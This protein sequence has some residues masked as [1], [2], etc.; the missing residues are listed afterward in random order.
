MGPPTLAERVASRL[1][2]AGPMSAM[3]ALSEPADRQR[4]RRHRGPALIARCA[5]AGDAATAHRF[6]RR[7]GLEITVRGGGHTFAGYAICDDGLMLDLN[8]PARSS[9]LQQ[10]AA[11]CAVAARPGVM[12]TPRRR[13]TAWPLTAPAADDCRPDKPPGRQVDELEKPFGI[14]FRDRAIDALNRPAQHAHR[15]TVALARLSLV[16]SDLRDLRVGEKRPRYSVE[17]PPT[18]TR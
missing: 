2:Q 8:R 14:A 10:L 12:W 18:S 3:L 13:R 11:R 7:N 15:S 4:R 16:Q 1:G 6:A 5:S 17:A 9:S